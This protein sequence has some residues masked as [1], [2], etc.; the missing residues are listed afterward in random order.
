MAYI[1]QEEKAFK[2]IKLVL[3]SQGEIEAVLC[4]LVRYR[5]DQDYTIDSRKIAVNI[6]KSLREFN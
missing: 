6:I 4:A 3:E 1:E 5:T 2:P